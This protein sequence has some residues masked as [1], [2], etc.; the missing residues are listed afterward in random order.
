M[1]KW[2]WWLFDEEEGGIIPPPL[3]PNVCTVVAMPR[4]A[5]TSTLSRLMVATPSFRAKP[6]C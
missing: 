5:V 6:E 1:R 2:L 4:F 3:D